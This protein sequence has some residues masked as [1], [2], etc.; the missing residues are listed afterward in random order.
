MGVGLKMLAKHKLD[1]LP[2]RVNH[3]MDIKNIFSRKKAV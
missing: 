1:I 3:M 2:S